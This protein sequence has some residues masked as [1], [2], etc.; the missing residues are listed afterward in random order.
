MEERYYPDRKFVE[1]V[2]VLNAVLTNVEGH[3][4]WIVT[5]DEGNKFALRPDS[6]KENGDQDTK[7]E[8]E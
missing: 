4:R 8:S 7:E 1:I 5:T 2:K 3:M 6:A